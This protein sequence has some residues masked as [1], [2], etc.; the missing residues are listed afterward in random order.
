MSET[1]F[2]QKRYLSGKSFCHVDLF[3][4]EPLRR[5][6]G[7]SNQKKSAFEVAAEWTPEKT[8]VSLIHLEKL[9]LEISL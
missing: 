6:S 5:T 2:R 7:I 1:F 8:K 3:D 9:K 4:Q